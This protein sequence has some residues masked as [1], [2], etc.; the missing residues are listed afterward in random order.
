MFHVCQ[1]KQLFA[2][3]VRPS[4]CTIFPTRATLRLRSS[5]DPLFFDLSS[6]PSLALLAPELA[7]THEHAKADTKAKSNGDELEPVG[8]MN[9]A[10]TRIAQAI[11][12]DERSQ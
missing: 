4:L 2:P 6:S 1:A 5:V 3:A 8:S 11:H 12:Q 7:P 9:P 10:E